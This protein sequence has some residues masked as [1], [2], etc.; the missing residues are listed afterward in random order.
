[1]PIGEKRYGPKERTAEQAEAPVGF[2]VPTLTR[3]GPVLRDPA[4]YKYDLFVVFAETD[5]EWVRGLSRAPNTQG[6]DERLR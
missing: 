6:C 1:V 2:G 3:S 5:G 4:A